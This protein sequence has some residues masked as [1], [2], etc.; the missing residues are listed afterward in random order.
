MCLPLL[1]LPQP[2][3]ILLLL[4]PL[5]HLHSVTTSSPSSSPSFDIFVSH[6]NKNVT[7]EDGSKSKDFEDEAESEGDSEDKLESKDDSDF[8]G[9]S[10]SDPDSDDDPE[11]DSEGDSEGDT[12]KD[13]GSDPDSEGGPN[14]DGQNFGGDHVS[15]GS[16]SGGGPEANTVPSSVEYSEQ[17]QRPQRIRQ[18]PR[19]FVEFDMLRD[20]KIDSEG[21][22]IQC[23]MLVEYELVNT[24]KHSRKKSEEFK[25]IERSKSWEFTKLPKEKK[26]ISVR[27]VFKIKLK[28]DRSI[29]KHKTS[30]VARGF[31]KNV[32]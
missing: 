13:C 25:A 24:E 3:P 4:L 7:S 15:E 17:V 8:K 2:S 9:E 29:G 31:F 18:I 26:V 12:D 14:F 30:L 16:V 11:S 5:P 28:L 19:R 22:F 23:A 27:M 32:F 20:T 21:E 6:R 1:P 10:D